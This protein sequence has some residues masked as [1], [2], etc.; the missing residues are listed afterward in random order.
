[1]TDDRD[2]AVADVQRGEPVAR[3]ALR[4][5]VAPATIRRWCHAAGV[6]PPR[7]HR[8]ITARPDVYPA[9]PRTPRQQA[10]YAA[11]RAEPGAPLAAIAHAA[12]VSQPYASRLIG[13]WRAQQQEEA[14]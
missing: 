1:M 13:Q 14:A 12:G 9:V 11:W 10:V 5:G 2:Y 6:Y 8:G 4:Y 7:Q 3:V